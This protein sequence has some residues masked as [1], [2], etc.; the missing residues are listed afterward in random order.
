L[1]ASRRRSSLATQAQLR[2]GGARALTR[3]RQVRTVE[4][5]KEFRGGP[6]DPYAFSPAQAPPPPAAPRPP[7]RRVL[8]R[9][10]ALQ[11]RAPLGLGHFRRLSHFRIPAR[12]GRRRARDQG[13]G[14]RCQKVRSAQGQKRSRAPPG[15]GHARSPAQARGVACA[16]AARAGSAAHTTRTRTAEGPSCEKLR[17]LHLSEIAYFTFIRDCVHIL[18]LSEHQNNAVA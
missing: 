4:G 6:D 7:R 18:R 3:A 10:A 14:R 17:I 1:A 5:L 9:W 8:R 2:R 11:R 12:R 13:G 16:R 15:R